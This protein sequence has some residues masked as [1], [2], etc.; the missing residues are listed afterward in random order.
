VESIAFLAKKL[1][2]RFFLFPVGLCF[3]LGLVGFLFWRRRP[4][5]KTGP[6][7][8]LVSLLLFFLLSMPIFG[9]LLLI[10]LEREAGPYAD[11]QVLKAKGVTHIVVLSGGVRQGPRVINDQLNGPGLSRLLEGI[12]LWKQL[13]GAKLFLTGG[14]VSGE[15][16]EA[17]AMARLARELGVPAGAIVKEER[18]WDTEDQAMML[19]SLLAGQPF[20]LVTSA[21]HMPRSLTLF[22]SMGLNPMP[23]PTEFHTI[24]AGYTYEDFLPQAGGLMAAQ[25]ALYEYW[26]RIWVWLKGLVR[27]T[28]PP[29]PIKEN[30]RF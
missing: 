15:R 19:R 10:P 12:R 29:V 9:G 20:A 5:A 14:R 8:V 13:P 2:S 1:I 22:K 21:A 18:S 11:P 4:W 17:G 6:V 30:G 26:G 25:T 23:A 3:L 24:G 16:S 28:P 27:G 7:L